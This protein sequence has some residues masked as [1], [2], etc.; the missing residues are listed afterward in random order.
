M[1]EAVNE[2]LP[3]SPLVESTFSA[4]FPAGFTTGTL[5]EDEAANVELEVELLVVVIMDDAASM[6]LEV[7]LLMLA[8]GTVLLALIEVEDEDWFWAR[9]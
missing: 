9:D 5:A 8:E 2:P 3:G 7:R 6:E 1:N 4:I